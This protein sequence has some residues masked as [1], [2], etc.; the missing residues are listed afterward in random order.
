[1]TWKSV[2]ILLSRHDLAD[3][4]FAGKRF[5]PIHIVRIEFGENGK[6]QIMKIG[7]MKIKTT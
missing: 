6:L 1:M 7:K 3:S 2:Y 4:F 5:A